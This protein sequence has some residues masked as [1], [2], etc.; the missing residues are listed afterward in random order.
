[1]NPDFSPSEPDSVAVV[2]QRYTFRFVLSLRVHVK[3]SWLLSRQM[4]AQF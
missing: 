4:S 2:I 1:M 3:S